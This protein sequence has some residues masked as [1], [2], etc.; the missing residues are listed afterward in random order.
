MALAQALRASAKIS[1]LARTSSL[2]FEN[3]SPGDRRTATC[4]A[5][6]ASMPWDLGKYARD[7]YLDSR[8]G[9]NPRPGSLEIPRWGQNLAADSIRYRT[10]TASRGAHHL[11]RDYARSAVL[12]ARA[13]LVLSAVCE[14]T[15]RDHGWTNET[16]RG[17]PRG[18]A[19]TILSGV[20]PRPTGYEGTKGPG[21]R[22]RAPSPR[23]GGGVI[24]SSLEAVWRRRRPRIAPPVS[25]KCVDCEDL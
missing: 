22:A 20:T 11:R 21:H 12:R 9:C 8:V 10:L 2:V 25:V 24:G 7:F 23:W 4:S 18:A 6:T 3:L 15:D 5:R 17:P 13:E 16:R 1:S 14:D 19:V